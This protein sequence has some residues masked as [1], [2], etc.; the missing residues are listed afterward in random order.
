[1]GHPQSRKRTRNPKRIRKPHPWLQSH[2]S[3]QSRP[4]N[5]EPHLKHQGRQL[6]PRPHP[7]RGR[8]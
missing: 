4:I 2:S 8:S 1:M 7:A 5:Q 3:P 6:H